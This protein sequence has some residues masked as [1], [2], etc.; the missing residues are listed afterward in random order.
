[1]SEE[2]QLSEAEHIIAMQN[3]EGWRIVKERYEAIIKN[4][5]DIRTIPNKVYDDNG[6]YVREATQEERL[7]EMIVREGALSLFQELFEGLEADVEKF[8]DVMKVD[9][10]EEE[11]DGIKRFEQ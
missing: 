3:S 5:S 6:N 7:K 11:S 1:M 9:M 2:K 10:E 4:L 8:H